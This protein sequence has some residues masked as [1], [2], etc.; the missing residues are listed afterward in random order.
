MDA[1]W[2]FFAI[3]DAMST[4]GIELTRSQIRLGTS[5][6]GGVNDLDAVPATGVQT[7]LGA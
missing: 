6:V 4:Y 1:S 5:A 2:C 7:Q 3:E